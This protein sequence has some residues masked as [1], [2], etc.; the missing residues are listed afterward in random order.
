MAT[1]AMSE[2]AGAEDT[3][4][5]GLFEKYL[6]LWVILCI[7]AGIVLGKVAPGLATFLDGLAIY[8]GEAPVVSIPIAVCLF[9]MM[10]PIMVKI[11]FAEV[12]KAGRSGKPV[13]LTLFVNWAI[14]P[15]SMYA[16]AILFLGVIFRGL[17]GA[18][19]TDLVKMPFGLDLP[20]GS[21]HGSGTVVLI[22]DIASVVRDG[23]APSY[24]AFVEEALSEKVRAAREEAL[25]AAFGEAAS[26]PAFLRDV[27]D[28]M[29]SFK[30][31]D[32]EPAG[33]KE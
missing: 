33:E 4:G 18:E 15:F 23:A 20:V 7:G 14:K 3:K 2:T 10:Y 31:V 12:I 13:G 5:L 27:E 22:D 16:I 8:V 24:S 30:H 29:D 19:A 6:T 28:T 17:I 21:T 26:D 11:D 32:D 9:F 25:A 1:E